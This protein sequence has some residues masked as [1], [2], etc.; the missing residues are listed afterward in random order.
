VRSIPL[1]RGVT[2]AAFI[3]ASQLSEFQLSVVYVARPTRS[4]QLSIFSF[5]LSGQLHPSPFLLLP[6]FD[7]S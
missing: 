3:S 6:S 5:Q 2:L 4:I 7:T 1:P